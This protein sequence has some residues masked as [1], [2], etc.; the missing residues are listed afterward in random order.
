MG[1]IK[2][3]VFDSAC[4]SR[5]EFQGLFKL[6]LAYEKAMG[7][8]WFCL[9]LMSWGMKGFRRCCYSLSVLTWS[10]MVNYFF[11]PYP[12]LRNHRRRLRASLTLTDKGGGAGSKI[13]KILLT[14]Y[15]NSPH[16]C[17]SRGLPCAFQKNKQVCM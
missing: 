4:F 3:W 6:I 9:F 1:V 8:S 15:L 7:S 10:L 11:Y 2:T 13:T 12:Y 17:P 16:I 14:Q 5:D